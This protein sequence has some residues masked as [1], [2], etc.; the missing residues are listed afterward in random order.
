M[1][2]EPGA[3]Q[4]D[5]GWKCPRLDTPGFEPGTKWSEVECATPRPSA[6]RPFNF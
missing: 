2:D 3:G 1:S 4:W 5:E 6:L